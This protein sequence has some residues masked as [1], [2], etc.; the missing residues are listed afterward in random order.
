MDVTYG[1]KCE[2]CDY[3]RGGF[4]VRWGG[5]RRYCTHPAIVDSDEGKPSICG[6]LG[7]YPLFAEG[8]LPQVT[9]SVEDVMF[10]VGLMLYDGLKG[11]ILTVL[12][13]Q[14]DN[15]DKLKAS[16]TITEDILS[17]AENDIKEYLVAMFDNWGIEK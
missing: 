2:A 11:K 9:T 5:Y 1:R 10:Q 14:I 12:E 16:K 7:E 13:S 17:Q 6:W 3:G 15:P 4:D 8:V